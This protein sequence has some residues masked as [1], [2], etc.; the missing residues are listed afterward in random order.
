MA[1]KDE[2]APGMAEAIEARM[3]ELG[4]GPTA[5]ARAAGV[6]TQALVPV[7]RGYRRAYQIKLKHGVARALKWPA[8]AIDRLL[9]GE[10]P[11]TFDDRPPA[12]PGGNVT[13]IGQRTHQVAD[14]DVV[15]LAALV[16]KLPPDKRQ[17]IEQLVRTMLNE[18]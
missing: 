6:T 5:V 8:D 4:M 3:A 1:G 2:V 18:T 7:R 15:E 12:P 13:P 16:G 17:A 14:E 9:A 11:S 10:D